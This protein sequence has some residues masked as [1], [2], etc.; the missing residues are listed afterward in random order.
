MLMRGKK[1]FLSKGVMLSANESPIRD[2]RIQ[3]SEQLASAGILD[4]AIP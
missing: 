4:S 3:L 2:H 1:L